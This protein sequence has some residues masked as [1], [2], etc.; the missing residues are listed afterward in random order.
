MNVLVTGAAG[1][2]GSV[3]AEALLARG[4]DVIALDNL[5]EGNRAAVPESAAFYETDLADRPALHSIFSRHKIDAVMHF[6]GEA[7]VAKSMHEPSPFYVGNVACGVILLDAMTRYNVKNLIFSS[8]C[9]V[10]GEPTILPIPEDH[11]KAPVNPYGQ[12]KLRFET[13]LSDYANYTGLRYISLRYFNAAGA[14]PERGEA[15]RN[16]THLIPRL[17]D[18]ALGNI[19][20]VEI[21]GADYPTPDGTCV[22]DYVHVLDIAAAHLRALACIDRVH[23]R[24]FNVG[25]GRGH[26]ILEVLEVVRRVTGKSLSHKFSPRRTGDPATLV[27]S[28]NSLHAGLGWSPQHSSLDEMV[29]SAWDWRLRHPHGYPT[30]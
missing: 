21:F 27:A 4:I 1:Y 12:S 7:L 10:Y 23:S 16:E 9:A 5:S 8:T 25:T 29:S 24:P 2:I 13:I 14:S 18:A 17:L 28:G 11:A 3:C 19:S 30:A 22:R 26:S 20:Q 15:H 6:A